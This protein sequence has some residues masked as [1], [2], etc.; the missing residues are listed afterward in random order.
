MTRERDEA[1]DRARTAEVEARNAEKLAESAPREQ[2]RLRAALAKAEAALEEAGRQQR[3]QVY[4]KNYLVGLVAMG[5]F[6]SSQLLTCNF[7]KL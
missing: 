5:G 4:Y 2:Q 3:E 1:A 7:Y 6:R